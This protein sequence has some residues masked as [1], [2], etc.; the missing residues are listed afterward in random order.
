MG[1]HGAASRRILNALL[2]GGCMASLSG[3]L[4]A[5]GASRTLALLLACLWAVHPVHGETLVALAGR[6][7]LLSLF[8]ILASSL[9]LLRARPGL[10]LLFAVLALLAR[11]SALPWL[12]ACAALVAHDRGVS[13]KRVVA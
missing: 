10:A 1:A 3:L 6:P 5:V 12:V 13:S 7:V 2:F 8:L 11:E 4:R 9:I